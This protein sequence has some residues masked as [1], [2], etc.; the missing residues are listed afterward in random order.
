MPGHH[1]PFKPVLYPAGKLLNAYQQK[2]NQQQQ[3]LGILKS[4]LPDDIAIHALYCVISGHKL[5][6]YTDSSS[7]S[8]QLRFYHLV[9][10]NKVVESGWKQIQLLQIRIIPE[11]IKPSL[12]H[13]ANIP[14]KKNIQFIRQQI[15]SPVTDKLN[16]ALLKLCD[17]LDRLS[18]KKD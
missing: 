3:I 12:Q 4:V 1:Q 8:S 2:I 14:S 11:Q 10:L 7:W 15:Q 18:T 6:V 5:L 16:N 13:S 9:M 17:T